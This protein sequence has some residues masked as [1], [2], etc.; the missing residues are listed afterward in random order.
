MRLRHMGRYAVVEDPDIN[1]IGVYRLDCYNCVVYDLRYGWKIM[2][3]PLRKRYLIVI[4]KGK[5]V[6]VMGRLGR[7]LNLELRENNSGWKTEL[8]FFLKGYRRATKADADRLGE[9]EVHIVNGEKG[10]IMVAK[11]YSKKFVVSEK[12]YFAGDEL[13]E[14]LMG[15]LRE[16]LDEISRRYAGRSYDE[17]VRMG[18]IEYAL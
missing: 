3:K 15:K 17:L 5:K 8:V 12:G 14:H 13:P 11:V 6:Y 1:F 10:T 18:A 4:Q 9:I 2:V 7:T 16:V